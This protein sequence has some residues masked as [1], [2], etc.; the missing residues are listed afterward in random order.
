MKKLVVLVAMLGL[1]NGC[2]SNPNPRSSFGEAINNIDHSSE[3]YKNLPLAAFFY[4][5]GALLDIRIGTMPYYW[6]SK[7]D[8]IVYTRPP[9]TMMLFETKDK[10]IAEAK[11]STTIHKITF[12]GDDNEDQMKQNIKKFTKYISESQKNHVLLKVKK[13]GDSS[14][15][16]SLNPDEVKSIQDSDRTT[17]NKEMESLSDIQIPYILFSYVEK[18]D[19]NISMNAPLDIFKFNRNKKDDKRKYFVALYP[20]IYTLRLSNDLKTY[21]KKQS[22]KINGIK[23]NGNYCLDVNENSI[24][25]NQGNSAF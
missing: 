19:K 3:N 22:K 11:D 17:M 21:A 23:Y 13:D 25:N 16:E 10:Y 7:D 24:E 4:P 20:S 9:T 5:N 15:Q 18:A 2:A 14:T 1:I 12:G 6:Y 8:K